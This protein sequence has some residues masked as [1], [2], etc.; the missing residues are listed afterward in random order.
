[1]R[2][3]EQQESPQQESPSMVVSADEDMGDHYGLDLDIK[4]SKNE[5]ASQQIKS[6]GKNQGTGAE[7]KVPNV[8]TFVSGRNL[9]GQGT[10]KYFDTSGNSISSEDFYGKLNPSKSQPKIAKS[11]PNKSKN[12]E[13]SASY[14]SDDAN[15]VVMMQPIILPNLNDGDVIAFLP[16]VTGG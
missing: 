2:Y 11:I 8:G 4:P 14:E 6:I 7:I 15:V 10:D 3:P 16:P 1:M 13:E 9:F 12:I 5:M